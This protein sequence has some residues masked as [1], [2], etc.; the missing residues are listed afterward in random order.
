MFH[1]LPL[2]HTFY[3]TL[4]FE[5]FYML[6]VRCWMHKLTLRENIKDEQKDDIEDE[7]ECDQTIPDQDK[8]QKETESV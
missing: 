4:H 1:W 7:G 8:V 3:V 6:H 5:S 2:C